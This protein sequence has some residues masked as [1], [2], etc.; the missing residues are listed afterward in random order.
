M[1]SSATSKDRFSTAENKEHG[2]IAVRSGSAVQILEMAVGVI[3]RILSNHACATAAQFDGYD[4][5]AAGGEFE[6]WPRF[7]A[8]EAIFLCDLVFARS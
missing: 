4:V 1:V 8:N 2:T 7:V 5:L 3:L 6:H